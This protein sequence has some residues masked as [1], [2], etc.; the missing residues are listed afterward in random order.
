MKRLIPLFCF[1]I[2]V[3]ASS[4]ADDKKAHTEA[5]RKKDIAQHRMLAQLH[6]TAAKCIEAGKPMRECHEQLRKDCK[7]AGIGKYCGMKHQH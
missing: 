2:A 3:S 6:D 1:L 5:E 4:Q 7:G